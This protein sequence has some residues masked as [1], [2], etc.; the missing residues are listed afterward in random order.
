MIS[1]DRV[2]KVHEMLRI[3]PRTK[4][5]FLEVLEISDSTFQRM[6][7]FM[8]D[9]LNAPLEYFPREHCYRYTDS[10][11][12]IPGLWFTE[13]ECD[14]LVVMDALLDQQGMS[15]IVPTLGRLR[16]R[17]HALQGPERLDFQETQ[18]RIRHYRT[19]Q[20]GTS[21]ASLSVVATA[22]LRRKRLRFD[23]AA[24]YNNTE[25]AEREVSPLRLS[26][27]RNNWYLIAWCHLRDALRCFSVENM[28]EAVVLPASA[29]E[30]GSDEL[31]RRAW[32]RWRSS[33][34]R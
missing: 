3:R 32:R 4:Q 16:E 6:T 1:M 27:Y 26:H 25:T 31:D 21:S 17:L 23:Y 34:R 22:T 2:R 14:A 15:S 29:L 33:N 10:S 8:R 13:E 24:R 11:F 12:E 20:R 5:E 7:A 18:K 28:K 9:R 30:I 19:G